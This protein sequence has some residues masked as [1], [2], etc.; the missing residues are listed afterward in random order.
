[1]YF[2][3]KGDGWAAGA[4]LPTNLQSSLGVSVSLDINTDKP[5][6]HNAEHVKQYPKENTN[7][8][9]LPRNERTH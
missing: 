7:R 8:G 2:Y 4:S 9:R 5:Y 1:M 3:M 6:E